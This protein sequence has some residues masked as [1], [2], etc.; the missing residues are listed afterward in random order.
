MLR[1]IITHPISKHMRR[2]G[3]RVTFAFTADEDGAIVVVM[4]KNKN[5]HNNNH[6]AFI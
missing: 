1:L 4:I 6:S 2:R 5:E 3:N